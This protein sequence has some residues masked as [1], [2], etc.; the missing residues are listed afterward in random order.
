VALLEEAARSK[1]R[2]PQPENLPVPAA[3]SAAVR[4]RWGRL[5]PAARRIAVAAAALPGD[6]CTSQ[7]VAIADLGEDAP[8]ALAE[9]VEA[10]FLDLRA[11]T[12]KVRLRS[13]LLGRA[14]L[15]LLPPDRERQLALRAR[16]LLGSEPL[17]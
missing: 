15:D 9:A 5:T 14:I 16:R 8:A 17:P 4:E 3:V 7:V 1:A 2:V 11:D 10:R 6:A 12:M 13:A